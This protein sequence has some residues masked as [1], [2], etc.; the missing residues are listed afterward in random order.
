MLSIYRA[1]AGAGKTHRLTGEY[2]LL[3][4]SQTNAYRRILA[5]TFTNKATNEMKERLM[6]SLGKEALAVRISTIHSLCVRIL[7]ED[8]RSI[9]YPTSFTILDTD[10]QKQILRPIYK[11]LDLDVKEFNMA[12]VLGMISGYK[13]EKLSPEQAV[14]YAMTDQQETIVKIYSRYEKKRLEIKAM[15]FDDLLIEALRLLESDAK[16]KEKWQ[17]RLD[18]IHVDEFQDV[19]P[20]QY[21]IVRYLVGPHAFLCVVGDP[22]QTIY[23]WRGASVDIILHF[24]C[25]FQPCKSVILDQNYRSTKP[26]LDASNA[27]IQNNKDRIKKDLYTKISGNDKIVLHVATEDSEE[28]VYIAR[29]IHERHQQGVAYKDMAIL[30]RSNYSSRAFERVFKSVRIPYKI[31]GGIRFYERQEIKDALAYLKLCTLPEPEDPK[32]LSFDLAIL[33]IINQPRRG[34]GQKTIEKLRDQAQEQGVNLLTVLKD[35]LDLSSGLKKKCQDFYSL[36]LDLQQHRDA[37]ALEDFLEYIIERSGYR[38]MLEENH[39]EERLDNLKELKSDIAQSMKEDPSMTLESYLQ[40]V[41]LFTSKAGD[42]ALDCVSLMTVHASKGLEFDT[43]F[44]VNFNEGIFPS[45]RSLNEGGNKALEEE[46]RLCYVAMT[47][48]KSHLTISWNTGFSYMLDTFKTKS[49]FLMEIPTEEC[50]M[51]GQEQQQKKE[52]KQ[53]QSIGI[54]ARKK[55]VG[56]KVKDRVEH[57]VFGPGIV[58]K[59]ERDVATIAFKHPYGIKQLNA[60]HPSLK[61]SKS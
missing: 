48:A 15:D 14:N 52:E 1:S 47:R 45:S 7:R 56:F 59:I 17:N 57:Q 12:H 53:I 19:D 32:Q 36:I 23:T 20:I 40:E 42:E 41:S 31:Y 58:L 43:V 39:E 33:R 37:L 24:D 9:G 6:A 51:E 27:L 60:T 29:K 8:A 16:V 30:Y 34:I 18:Y 5:V 46:R 35:P 50:Y 26:I 2:L 49:R 10:D 28:P 55:K 25:D 3:L 38:Q 22:D 21:A 11:E 13:S 54:P 4:Y 44:I 61:K